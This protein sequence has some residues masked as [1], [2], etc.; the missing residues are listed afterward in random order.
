MIVLTPLYLWLELAFGVSLL[1]KMGSSLP[2]DAT[3][4]V[5]HWGRLISGLALALDH[6]G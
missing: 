4:A 2:I 3:A 1:D 6:A 5:E